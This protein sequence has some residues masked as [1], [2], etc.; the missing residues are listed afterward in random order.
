[1][2][3]KIPLGTGPVPAAVGSIRFNN[4]LGVAEIWNGSQWLS[5]RT[6][7]PETWAEWFDY[8]I[9]AAG[10]IP[11]QYTRQVHIQQEMQARFPGRYRIDLAGQAWKMVFDTPS[12]ETWWR[13]K[14]D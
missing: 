4:T 11:D 7:D 2:A 5:V 8:Y 1:V 9:D 10:N 13:L 14:Y 12:D 3:T 6:S